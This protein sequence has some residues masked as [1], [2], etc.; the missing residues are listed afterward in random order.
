MYSTLDIVDDVARHQ[1]IPNDG[2]ITASLAKY[3]D[4]FGEAHLRRI[5]E[6]YAAYYNAASY[7]PSLYIT[8]TNRSGCRFRCPAGVERAR[9]TPS[10]RRFA[11]SGLRVWGGGEG[12]RAGAKAGHSPESTSSTR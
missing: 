11:A 4:V 3:V 5:L 2:Q 10:D 1:C 7:Y 12:F 6:K 9:G 8:D